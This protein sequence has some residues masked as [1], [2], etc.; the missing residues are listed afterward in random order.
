M[1]PDK[2][3]F[4]RTFRYAVENVRHETFG[5]N[6][7]QHE[8]VQDVPRMAFITKPNGWFQLIRGLRPPSV[9]WE[10]A[11]KQEQRGGRWRQPK[12]PVPQQQFPQVTA[13]TRG[14]PR[15]HGNAPQSALGPRLKTSGLRPFQD[16]ESRV[17]A[18]KSR[19][20][21][22]GFGSN[23]RGSRAAPRE[24]QRVRK[25]SASGE[26]RSRMESSS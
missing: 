17:V 5:K 16:P 10:K 26:T 7:V 1:P 20:S 18:T 15:Q 14:A 25:G 23:G 8:D 22:L 3:F 19:V 24:S 6:T 21:R 4:P 13:T 11:P 12:E 2:L 9:R